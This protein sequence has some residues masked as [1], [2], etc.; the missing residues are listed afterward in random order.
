MKTKHKKLEDFRDLDNKW[1]LEKIRKEIRKKDIAYFDEN[2]R[3][4]KV[5]KEVE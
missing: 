2:D 3:L 5:K 4:V 1:Y